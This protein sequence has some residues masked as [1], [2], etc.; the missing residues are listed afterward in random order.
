M[1]RGVVQMA[2]DFG[3]WVKSSSQRVATSLLAPFRR[4]TSNARH[5]GLG[6]LG[7][8]AG[9]YSG[10]DAFGLNSYLREIGQF[11]PLWVEPYIQILMRRSVMPRLALILMASALSERQYVV[12]GADPRIEAFHQRWIDAL[13]PQ[14]LRSATNAIWYGWQP[15]VLDWTVDADG[16]LVPFKAHDLDPFAAEALESEE[17][18]EFVGLRFEGRDYALDR[19]FKLTWEGHYG[20]HYGEPQALTVYPYWWAWSVL[21]TQTM[22]YYERSVDPVR[23]AFVRNVQAPTGE[24]DS[25]TNKPVY[26]DLS[27]L[28]A[29]ALDVAAGGDSVS[30]PMGEGEELVKL[31]QLELPDRADTFLKMLA[32]LEQKQFLGT[33]SLPGLGVSSGFGE[34]NAD[35]APTAEKT[36]MRLLEY[37]TD[38]PI[39]ALNAYLLPHVHRINRLP[40]P[41]PRARGKAFKREQEE[42]LRELFKSGLDQ[43]RP[44]VGPDGKPTGTG[45]RPGDLIRW[46]KLGRQLDLPLHEVAEVAQAPDALMP[47]APGKG[48]RPPEPLGVPDTP[49]GNLT[50]A[51]QR[52]RGFDR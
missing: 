29:E 28:V 35:D 43:A 27:R 50:R 3:G 21:L 4:N 31:D 47:D 13:L 25:T 38:Q 2:V 5:H 8:L 49:G 16:M 36:Q 7:S 10:F 37:V 24:I 20:N 18:K 41:V 34:F 45:Y 42:T 32:Y 1:A 44:V 11:N 33:L 30:V 12:E 51:E 15:Y 39:D 48:G 19:A 46:D 40:G 26:V 22:R 23:I 52:S 6:S 17:A 14:L 9:F